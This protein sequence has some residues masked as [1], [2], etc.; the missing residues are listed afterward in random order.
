M[1][2]EAKL[3]RRFSANSI[4]DGISTGIV[5]LDKDLRIIA[6]NKALEGLSGKECPAAHA[7]AVFGEKTTENEREIE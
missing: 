5:I 2:E 1:D 6:M 4:I 7:L 3:N